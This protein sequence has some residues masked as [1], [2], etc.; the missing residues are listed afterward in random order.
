MVE[1]RIVIFIGAGISEDFGVDTFRGAVRFGK[2]GY[3]RWI[4]QR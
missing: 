4:C 1:E 3:G 2:Q